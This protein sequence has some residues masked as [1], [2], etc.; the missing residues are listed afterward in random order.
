MRSKPKK[1]IRTNAVWYMMMTPFMLV[2]VIFLLIPVLSSVVLSFTS[3]DMVRKPDFVGFD[4]YV[5][6]FSTTM[7][8]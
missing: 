3:F 8:L 1:T 5:R 6:R 4:N 7:C 2:F